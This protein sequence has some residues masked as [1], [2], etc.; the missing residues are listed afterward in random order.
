LQL[1]QPVASAHSITVE[2]ELAP[3]RS[4]YVR[5]DPQRLKQVLLNLLSNAVKYNKTGGKVSVTVALPSDGRARV[6]I[7]DTGY[8]IPEES[9]HLLFVPFERLDA[10]ATGIEG[11]GLGLALSLTLTE[12]MGGEMGVSSVLGEGCTFWVELSI[13]EPAALLE[14]SRFDEQVV[15]LKPYPHAPTILYVEDVRANVSLIEAVLARRPGAHLIS[16][17]LGEVGL[18]LAQEHQPELILLDLHLP[19]MDGLEVLRR[20]RADPR[21]ADIPVIVL[22][23]DATNRQRDAL[24]RLGATKYLTKPVGVQNLLSV[25]DELVGP[26][27]A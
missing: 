9:L 13:T 17:M 10:A 5:A 26:D 21:T 25:L 27:V 4:I 16:A 18:G 6:S 12:A 24:L 11:T 7:A 20:L 14:R 2:S 19:D 3:V 1:I 23:A 15:A 22:S 8:G